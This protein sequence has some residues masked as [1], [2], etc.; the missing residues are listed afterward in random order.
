MVSSLKRAAEHLFC[1]TLVFLNLEEKKNL[2]FFFIT[3]K[4]SH[5]K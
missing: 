2:F 4:Q 5:F 3:M 1:L